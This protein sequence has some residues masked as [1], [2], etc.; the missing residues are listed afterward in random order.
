VIGT[1][2]ANSVTLGVEYRGKRML[3]PGDLESPGLDD[4]MAELPYDCDVLMAPH[5]CSRRSDP[6]GFAPWC[7]PEWVVFSG[8]AR[9]PADVERTYERGG[10]QVFTTGKVG[11]VEELLGDGGVQVT[12]CHERRPDSP[13]AAP[14][15]D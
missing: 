12:A 13:E 2:N 1:D 14:S 10:A 11:E 5:H 15:E 8:D 7:T 3:L 9:V 4:L 6:P